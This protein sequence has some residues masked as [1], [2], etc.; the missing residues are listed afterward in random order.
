MLRLNHNH[1]KKKQRPGD[2]IELKAFENKALEIDDAKSVIDDEDD[3]DAAVVVNVPNVMR[4]QD[5]N[6][7]QSAAGLPP[8]KEDLRKSSAESRFTAYKD[9][10]TPTPP[11]AT[12]MEMTA[13]A[14]DDSPKLEVTTL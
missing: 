3:D 2:E 13:I 10:F 12:P 4:L 11:P 9:I 7:K 8:L 6:N 5:N 1:N 14:F